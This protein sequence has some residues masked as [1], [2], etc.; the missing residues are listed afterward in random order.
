MM[1]CFFEKIVCRRG[2]QSELRIDLT[3]IYY[4]KELLP[5]VKHHYLKTVSQNFINCPAEHQVF[6]KSSHE[7]ETYPLKPI[8]RKASMKYAVGMIVKFSPDVT[9][10]I[11]GWLMRDYNPRV[12][13]AGQIRAYI[14][15]CEDNRIFSISGIHLE[16]VKT[17]QPLKN[18]VLGRYFSAFNGTHYIPN[19]TVK[20]LYPDDL[21]YLTNQLSQIVKLRG[22]RILDTRE[23]QGQ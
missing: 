15:L 11:I 3:H 21:L 20:R 19:E 22:F 17:P 13:Y 7:E 16:K 6:E 1:I 2:A 12:Q 8:K 4:G 10:V 5:Y 23:L 18:D 14:V 9:G